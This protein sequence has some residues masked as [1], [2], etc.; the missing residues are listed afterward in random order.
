MVSG[1]VFA[2]LVCDDGD[3]WCSDVGSSEAPSPSHPVIKLDLA[4]TKRLGTGRAQARHRFCMLI[5]VGQE[6]HESGKLNQAL[7]M[8]PNL[9][10]HG[11]GSRNG[12]NVSPTYCQPNKIIA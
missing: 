2:F 7:G 6:S 12:A 4:F 10:G 11:S 9:V 1:I 3:Q 5:K 8:R